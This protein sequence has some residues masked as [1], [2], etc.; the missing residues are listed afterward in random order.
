MDMLNRIS[1]MLLSCANCVSVEAH[2]WDVAPNDERAWAAFVEAMR[3]EEAREA[4]VRE[5]DEAQDAA[6]PAEVA[7]RHERD[8]EERWI[9]GIRRFVGEDLRRGKLG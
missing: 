4:A 2:V 7:E 9:E 8:E 6:W 3:L 5:R 1:S